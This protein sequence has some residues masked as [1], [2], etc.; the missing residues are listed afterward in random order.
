MLVNTGNRNHDAAAF[1]AESARQ[2]ADANAKATFIAG[3]TDAA[4]QAAL[5]ANSV[6]FFRS[7]VASGVA[8]GIEVG[9]FRE[10]IHRLTGGV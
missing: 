7:V 2:V 6:A 9:V 5:N 1:A 10:G 8:N 4:Y 3:G